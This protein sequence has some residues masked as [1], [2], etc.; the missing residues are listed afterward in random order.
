[1][2]PLCCA[3]RIGCSFSHA[4]VNGPRGAGD[5]IPRLSQ[6]HVKG[7]GLRLEFG[8]DQIG[9]SGGGL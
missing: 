6:S 8:E 9:T 7:E 5:S 4:L 1:M 3:T 2:S